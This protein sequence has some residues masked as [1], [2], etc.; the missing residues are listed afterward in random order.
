MRVTHRRPSRFHTFVHNLMRTISASG[1]KW[2][3]VFEIVDSM[4]AFGIISR[5]LQ[6]DTTVAHMTVLRDKTRKAW[7]RYDRGKLISK[8]A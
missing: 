6:A 7:R 8:D 4:M 3:K 5:V 1:A 2:G